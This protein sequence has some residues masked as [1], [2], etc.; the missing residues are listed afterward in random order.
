MRFDHVIKRNG[1]NPKRK[2]LQENVNRLKNLTAGQ[3]RYMYHSG[4]EISPDYPFPIIDNDLFSS[5]LNAMIREGPLRNVDLL[6]GVTADEAL[7]FAEEHIFNHYLPRKYRTS[8]SLT[9]T[10]R[11]TTSKPIEPTTTTTPVDYSARRSIDQDPP[12]RG[13][14]YFRKNNYIKNYLQTNYPDRLCYFE[15]IRQRYMPE[16][17]HQHNLTETARLYTNLVSDLMFYYDLIRFLH[18]RLRSN[19]TRST[20]VYY[21]TNPPI[22]DLDNLLRRVPDMIGHFAELDLAWGVPFLNA[23]NHSN[24]AYTMNISYRPDE[25]ELSYQLI[26]YWTNFAK[27][28]FVRCSWR[29]RCASP[30]HF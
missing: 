20:Y 13:F 22:F 4:L 5:D 15:E 10:P 1:M 16:L 2:F 9:T 24:M 27:T 25:V 26:R 17:D 6:V 7:Y 8:P 12:P 3:F 30:L 29:E 14:S 23:R 19:A 18:E 21:Y 28:G 11:P